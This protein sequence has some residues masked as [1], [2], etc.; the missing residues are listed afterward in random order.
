MRN[1]DFEVRFLGFEVRNLGFE[2]RNLNSEAS[3]LDFGVG[4]VA[5]RGPRRRPLAP[6]LALEPHLQFLI[7]VWV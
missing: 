2:V 7:R 5:P 3:N 1:L 4:G 6:P